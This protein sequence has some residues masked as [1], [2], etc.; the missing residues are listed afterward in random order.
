MTDDNT[1]PPPPEQ[2]AAGQTASGNDYTM[3]TLAH[4]T[5]FT[6]FLG[7]LIFWL[8]GKDQ[9]AFADEEGKKALNFGILITIGYVLSIIPIIGWI[10]WAAAVIVALIFG[11]QG[12]M[13]A[14]KGQP[15]KY[16]FSLNLV[17]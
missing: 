2:P 14:S 6:G 9:S 4:A 11:I 16:P 10:I 1:T 12:A 7:P 17:K 8:I 3:A 13:A 5:V 15:F